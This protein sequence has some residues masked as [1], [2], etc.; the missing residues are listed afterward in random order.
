MV[1]D[2]TTDITLWNVVAAAASSKIYQDRQG[3]TG[4][5]TGGFLYFYAPM[6]NWAPTSECVSRFFLQRS[7]VIAAAASLLMSHQC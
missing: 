1:S 6:G 3:G 4:G 2:S 7:V 5:K